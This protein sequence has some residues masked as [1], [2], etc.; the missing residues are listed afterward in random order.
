MAINEKLSKIDG[1]EGIDASTY[2]NLVRSLIYL[3]DTRLRIMHAASVV[4][5]F[6]SEPSK[7][8][9]TNSQDYKLT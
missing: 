3:T 6:M 9:F 7:D 5:R 8:H 1:K 2:W 4:S